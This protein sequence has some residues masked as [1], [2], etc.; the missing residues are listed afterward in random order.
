MGANDAFVPLLR[1]SSTQFD[2][3]RIG[4]SRSSVG[5]CETCTGVKDACT[6]NICPVTK[7]NGN[8]EVAISCIR[9]GWWHDDNF[10]LA[11]RSIRSSR[12]A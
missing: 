8:V 4:R 1:H 7:L 3:G 10:P 6:S 2:P 9:E 11:V 12:L 5:Q